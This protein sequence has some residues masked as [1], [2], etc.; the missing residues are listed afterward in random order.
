MQAQKQKKAG[1]QAEWDGKPI[2]P[3]RWG[4]DHFTTLLYVETVC[5]DGDGQPRAEK[6]RSEPGR[7][8]RGKVGERAFDPPGRYPTRLKDGDLFGHDDWDCVSD[9]EHAG[10]IEWGGTGLQPILKLTDYG[11]LVAG[12]LRRARAEG[13]NSSNFVLPARAS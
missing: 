7:P 2:P 3:E 13:I 10:L 9:M 4:R 1:K 6:M 11:W 5:V 12:A 8:R